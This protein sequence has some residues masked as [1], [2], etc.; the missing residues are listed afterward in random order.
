MYGRRVRGCVVRVRE[1][2][3]G[4]KR[5]GPRKDDGRVRVWERRGEGVCSEGVCG[6]RMR[7][8]KM[9]VECVWGQE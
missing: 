4:W 2:R 8:R 5:M 7:M 6:D 1:G 9:R 3:R